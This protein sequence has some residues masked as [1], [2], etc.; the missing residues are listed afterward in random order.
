MQRLSTPDI[1][2]CHFLFKRENRPMNYLNFYL[3][4]RLAVI[5]PSAKIERMAGRPPKPIPH[6]PNRIR[7]A[8]EKAGLTQEQLGRRIGVKGGSIA[9]YETG[10]NAVSVHRLAQIARALGI[11]AYTLLVD[12]DP[13]YDEM[14]RAILSALRRLSPT[15]R[16]RLLR[17]ALA[18]LPAERANGVDMVFPRNVES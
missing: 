11:P 5:A 14:E 17:T 8:R 16:E 13:G 7:E 15:D 2:D 3:N 18:W 6:A 12:Y 9:K 10:E 4:S 1:A